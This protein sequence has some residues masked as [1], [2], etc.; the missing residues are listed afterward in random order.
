VRLWEHER[1]SLLAKINNAVAE[2]DNTIERLRREKFKQDSDLKTADLRVLTLFQELQ[3][4]K[5]FEDKE[6]ALFGNLNKFRAAKSQ[7]VTECADFE[8]QLARKLAEI[9]LWKEK[10]VQV[11]TEFQQAVGGEKHGEK[12]EH[13][14]Q[15][16][17]I[18][19]KKLKR[20]KKKVRDDDDEGDS[21]D[22]EEGGSEEG[23]GDESDSNAEDDD[24]CPPGCE[25]SVYEKVLELRE[26]RLEQEEILTDFVKMSKELERSYNRSQENERK[27]NSDLQRTED[28]IEQFQT[29]K[30]RAL[31]S[32]RVTIPLKLHQLKYL[33]NGRLPEDISNA[34]I[35]TS[36]G[37]DKLRERIVFL[38][39]QK[40]ALREQF[41][42]RKKEHKAL[43]KE[44]KDKKLQIDEEKK[45]CEDVQMLKFGQIIDMSILEKVKEDESAKVL[46][47]RLQALEAS[48]VQRVSEWD[49]KI[50]G[51]R[52][53]LARITQENTQ[54][55]E[56]VAQLTKAQYDLEHQ[57]NATTK[58][59]HIADT[60]PSDEKEN[61]ERR[62]LL[63]LVQ[64][65]E[66][67][68]DALKAEIHVLR[69]KGGHV[70]TPQ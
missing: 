55:L 59:V 45:K 28:E 6:N 24:Q 58:N 10:D 23:S 22:D 46:R 41:K 21:D 34:L 70:Y 27:I 65:Q 50:Q 53:E 69:R 38:G 3:L 25:T 57:L 62:Q 1:S 11:L 33:V 26:R 4:L 5:S 64:V 48:S 32:I 13:Y 39:N 20:G 7:V 52:D 14:H 42:Q 51:A 17:K 49:Q 44:L 63:G 29:Q 47:D 15:L 9:K 36:T 2:F 68:I 19:K 8:R 30:Q 37:L 66:R 12:S 16:F 35:F 67:E 61:S 56:R 54:W 60:R 43:K 40:L 31:N 18:F